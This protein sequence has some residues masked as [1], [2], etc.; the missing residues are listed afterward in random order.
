[1]W[2]H[3]KLLKQ[4]GALVLATVLSLPSAG[5]ITV[6]AEETSEQQTEV[7]TDSLK[8]VDSVVQNEKVLPENAAAEELKAGTKETEEMA[9]P[10]LAADA[11]YDT[12]K[13]I[14]EGV[15][16]D[17]N[18][19]TIKQDEEL[20]IS[21]QA[22]DADSGI[23]EITVGF[24]FYDDADDDYG[25]DY[26]TIELEATADGSKEYV[27][28]LPVK[29]IILSKGR[30]ASIK[31][32]DKMTNYTMYPVE[33][34]GN[35][36]YTFNIEPKSVENYK[37]TDASF[38]KSGSTLKGEETAEFS[39]K[40]TPDKSTEDPGSFRVIFKNPDTSDQNSV[41]TYYDESSG[42]YSGTI[43]PNNFYPSG[44][45]MVDSFVYEEGGKEFPV[46]SDFTDD[47]WYQIE[48]EK[49]EDTEAPKIT[50]VELDKNRQMLNPGDKVTIKVT[51]EDDVALNIDSASIYFEAAEDIDGRSQYVDL[52]YKDGIFEGVF[53]IT[54]DTYPC[55]WYVLDIN[56]RDTAG[57]WAD[58]MLHPQYPYYIRVKNKDTFVNPVYE[59]IS[60]D[61]QYIN[62]EGDRVYSKTETR[63]NVERRTTYKELGI[64]FPEAPQ[65]EGLTFQGWKDYNGN[66]IDENT[67]IAEPYL[68]V[69][70]IYDKAP[71]M[72][73][74]GYYDEDG[75]WVTESNISFFS[76]DSKKKEIIAEIKKKAVPENGY[77][78]FKEWYISDEEYDSEETI[79]NTS[80]M[81]IYAQAKYDKPLV[82]FLVHDSYK[83]L[84]GE[85]VSARDAERILCQAANPGDAI[86]IPA[87]N[88][89]YD[90]FTWVDGLSEEEK[91]AG[92]LTVS[93]YDRIIYGYAGEKGNT[94]SEDTKDPATPS[95][96]S[97][98]TTPSGAEL[99]EGRITQIVS[100]IEAVSEGGTLDIPM[101]G[102]TVIPKTVLE[103]AKG[104]DI[105]LHIKMNGY[106]WTING[107]DIIASNLKD[108][109]L[110]VKFNTNAIPSSTVKELA[111]DN[112]VQQLSLTHNGD[113]GFKA[114]LT[115]NA[116]AEFAGKHGNLYWYDSDHKMK[117]V[118]AGVIQEDGSVSLVFSHASDYAL[119]IKAESDGDSGIEV[120][121]SESNGNQTSVQQEGNDSSKAPRTGDPASFSLFFM[122]LAI[123]AAAM[124]MVLYRK[125]R[126]NS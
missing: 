93:D 36:K 119:V 45:Y 112:P 65:F 23:Q 62:E 121:P 122:L 53:E 38:E 100:E 107:K 18:G 80:Q 69:Y 43:F 11:Q 27:G 8:E 105:L 14:I 29:G 54:K 4:A 35:Y 31:A 83:D 15:S 13:P 95:N 92:E 111:G 102:A 110:E 118:D 50:S 73:T 2:K 33:E 82:Q 52:T 76:K 123:S 79:G 81:S 26:Q 64:Q 117:Y 84:M 106:T 72:T 60:I 66:A 116:G 68:S 46:S 90:S 40:V 77:V 126:F 114:A 104:K 3:K 91:K 42:L 59:T 22:Y 108:I 87:S 58:P 21:V 47:V 12:T 70:A 5:A 1:M 24:E 55:E 44:K 124:G 34:N 51:A 48:T 49:R 125:R 39:F 16:F 96:P 113:F 28:T 74:Y 89:K 78:S 67:P 98:P 97:I 20:K 71:V 19:K 10:K 103:T 109:N 57:N 86:K 56:I 61:F 63:E 9:K 6:T 32:V 41:Y 101:D 120:L 85:G 30:I 88:E 25:H 17:Q 115:M 94:G 7:N 75:Y 37:I 99:P